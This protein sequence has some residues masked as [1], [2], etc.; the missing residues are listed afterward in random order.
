MGG[1]HPTGM[2]SCYTLHFKCECHFRQPN[3]ARI[4]SFKK[5][6]WGILGEHNECVPLPGGPNSFIFMQFSAENLQNNPS[7]GIGTSPSGKSWICHWFVC[8][9]HFSLIAGGGVC[10]STICSLIPQQSGRG[11]CV[12]FSQG[13]MVFLGRCMVF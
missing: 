8:M 10:R 1:T 4:Y 6:H 9:S 7:L 5:L 13:C 12:V 11:A 3:F 2:H